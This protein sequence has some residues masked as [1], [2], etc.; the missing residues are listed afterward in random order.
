MRCDAGMSMLGGIKESGSGGI[1]CL[2][3]SPRRYIE[4]G[5]WI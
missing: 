2:S 3:I 1:S 5:L 4:I